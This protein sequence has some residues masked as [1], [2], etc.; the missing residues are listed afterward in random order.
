MGKTDVTIFGYA[1][2]YTTGGCL[3]NIR[4]GGP[5]TIY[6]PL[7]TYWTKDKCERIG[8]KVEIAQCLLTGKYTSMVC[9][10]SWVKMLEISDL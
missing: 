9:C 4:E 7:A 1:L 5:R 6:K 2:R 10:R 8:N 3:H